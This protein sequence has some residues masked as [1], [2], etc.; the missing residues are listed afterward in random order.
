MSF[1]LPAPGVFVAGGIRLRLACHFTE[2]L[3]PVAPTPKAVRWAPD[4]PS[5]HLKA[6]GC[7][8]RYISQDGARNQFLSIHCVPSPL[9]RATRI[10]PD[11][12]TGRIERR[13]L[14]GA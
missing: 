9:S 13:Q 6:G 1:G 11:L 4:I 10:G 5:E 2:A 14:R 3:R 8:L 7:K 12:A